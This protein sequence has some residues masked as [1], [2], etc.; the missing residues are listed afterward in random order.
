[1][2]DDLTTW[3][4]PRT[5]QFCDE[6]GRAVHRRGTTTTTQHGTRAT[7]GGTAAAGATHQRSVTSPLRHARVSCSSVRGERLLAASR[8]I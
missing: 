2:T 1:M 8:E 4:L 5:T 7:A 6:L 3:L